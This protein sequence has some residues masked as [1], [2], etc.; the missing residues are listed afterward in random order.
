MRI[1][2]SAR[3]ART[4][5][6]VAASPAQR[7]PRASVRD[8]RLWLGLAVVVACVVIGA[9]VVGR[10]GDTV[11]VWSA[12]RDIPAGQ[13]IPDDALTAVLVSRTTADLGYL[14]A[15]EPASGTLVRGI[16]RGELVPAAALGSM[17][18]TPTRSVTVPVDPGHY[19]L[20]LVA[21]DR[22]DVWV[23]PADSP[24]AVSVPALTLASA[25]VRAITDDGL[26][27]AGQSGVVLDVPE[28]T[29]PAVVSAVRGGVIDLVS[30]P[31]EAQ[32]AT[33]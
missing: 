9:T 31:L 30:V 11:R 33:A 5:T 6:P 8:L 2:G 24:A 7:L 4:R 27:L 32:A 10:A 18:W 23:T 16:A 22:V 28:E 25:R 15:D 20:G 26:G 12:T 29:V 17:D 19:P 3:G 1:L 21:G 13:S 14:R